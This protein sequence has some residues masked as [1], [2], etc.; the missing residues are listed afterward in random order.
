LTGALKL[1]GAVNL[2]T[3]PL[4][5]SV[6]A[7]VLLA[8]GTLVRVVEAG[9]QTGGG[10]VTTTAMTGFCLEYDKPQPM[11][12][13][14]Y[15]VAPESLQQQFQPMR[16]LLE[17][18]RKLAEDGLPNPD[19]EAGAYGTF[20]QQRSLWTKLKD[21]DL[22][23]FTREFIDRTK[24]NVEN[25]GGDWTNAMRD[26][27]RDAAPNRFNDITAVLLAAEGMP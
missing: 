19:S 15:Q 24:K 16:K 20:I 18:G 3:A 17:A 2:L 23:E 1:P 22:G 27:L 4:Q 26:A 14:L 13:T 11:E 12:G 10:V 8:P 25:L 9:Q 21:W 6:T 7:P 5:A